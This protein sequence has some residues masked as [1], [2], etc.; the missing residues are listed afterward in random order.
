MPGQGP[1]AGDEKWVITIE[2]EGARSLEQSK[3]L[4]DALNRIVGR[5]NKPKKKATWK[6]KT[7]LKRELVD[8]TV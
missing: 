3:R 5:L 6:G 7:K 4:R 1:I 8:F 2:V